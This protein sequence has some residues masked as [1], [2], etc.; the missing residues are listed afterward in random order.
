[1]ANC[2]LRHYKDIKSKDCWYNRK[3]KGGRHQPHYFCN[4]CSQ[5]SWLHIGQNYERYKM[6]H[7]K[8]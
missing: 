6:E 5:K 4:T 8:I 2:I 7:Y 3:I 1:M